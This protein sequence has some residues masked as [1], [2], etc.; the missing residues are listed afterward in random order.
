MQPSKKKKLKFFIV[1]GEASGDLHGARLIRE[2][3]QL[4][5]DSTFLGLGGPMLQ[6]EGVNLVEQ[7]TNLSYVGF[8]EVIKHLPFF[9]RL[10]RQTIQTIKKF[11]PDHIILID[12]PGFNLRLAKRCRDLN[13][14]ITYFILPQVWAWK[15]KRVK[16]IRQYIHQALCILPF[17]QAWFSSR[18]ITT[19]FVGHP[20]AEPNPP[21]LDKLSFF[22]KHGINVHDPV[23]G[24]FPG[25]RQ[26]EIDRHWPTFMSTVLRL[27]KQIPGLKAIVGK[28]EL[29]NIPDHTNNI[30]IE[31]TNPQLVLHYSTAAIVASGSATLEAAVLKIPIIVCY[32]LSTVTWLLIKRMSSVKYAS[33]VNLIADKPVVPEFLQA[34][35]QSD[36][37]ADTLVALINNT[38]DRKTML[39]NYSRIKKKLGSPGVY[40]RAAKSVLKYH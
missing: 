10:M 33:L 34:D 38:T 39:R 23:L 28:S 6:K 40:R 2:I 21:K 29:V 26:Q 37:M 11:Q 31:K 25:S 14:P 36:K 1:A 17:E 16:I 12:Y 5:S 24:L 22:S 20:F 3:K 19:E 27:Q 7:I 32:K 8:T 9:R 35:L 30:L 13:I 18:G 15:E 4:H